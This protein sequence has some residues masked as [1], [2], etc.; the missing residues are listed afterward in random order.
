MKIR[1]ISGKSHGVESPVRPLGGCWYFHVIFSKLG[2]IFQDIRE[3]S[4]CWRRDFGSSPLLDI[5]A[6][7]TT[8]LYSKSSYFGESQMLANL[9]CVALKGAVRVGSDSTVHGPFHTLVLS[10]A[11][12]ETGIELTA[13]EDNTEFILVCL[14]SSSSY[15]RS[16]PLLS[17]VRGR[18]ARPDRGPV[19]PL[20]DDLER[21]HPEDVHRLPVRPERLREGTR[22]EE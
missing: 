14:S 18:A 9:L 2:T 3:Y 5:A 15:S 17:P 16:L 13:T 8:F 19:R 6:G 4:G 7:W 1:V 12:D 20:R 10:A 21:G 22:L 11:P